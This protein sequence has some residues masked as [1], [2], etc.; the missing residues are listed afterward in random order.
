MTIGAINGKTEP[1]TYGIPI[2]I[3]IANSIVATKIIGKAIDLKVIAMI[4]KIK[5]IE[6]ALTILKSF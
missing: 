2:L 1:V 4:I 6:T 3:L 5:I